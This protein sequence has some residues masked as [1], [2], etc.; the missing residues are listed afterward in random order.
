[1]SR[2]DARNRAPRLDQIGQLLTAAIAV[3]LTGRSP[4][5]R[6]GGTG[7]IPPQ[8]WLNSPIS[9]LD[10]RDF[11]KGGR[12]FGVHLS[13][14]RRLR[15]HVNY[16]QAVSAGKVSSPRVLAALVREMQKISSASANSVHPLTLEE[17]NLF[18]HGR[19]YFGLLSRIARNLNL[20]A[21]FVQKAGKGLYRSDKVM[22]AIRAEMARV[23]AEL[24]AQT[25][26]KQ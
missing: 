20:S 18:K 6:R 26:G 4:L 16:V 15:T 13:V 7:S 21:D 17:R 24:A 9:K 5:R 14:A 1:M 3:M 25:G 2:R 10:R 19:R 12:F 22:A 23:D 8:S 11:R